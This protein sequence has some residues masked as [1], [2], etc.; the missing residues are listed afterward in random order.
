MKEPVKQSE[1]KPVLA[2]GRFRVL[3][4]LAITT[5]LAVS[6]L[7]LFFFFQTGRELFPNTKDSVGHVIRA[8]G[9]VKKTPI[10]GQSSRESREDAWGRLETGHG[11]LETLH[12]GDQIQT[13]E[14]SAAQVLFFG[15]SRLQIEAASL[16]RFE[17]DADSIAIRMVLG[18][19]YLEISPDKNG[20]QLFAFRKSDGTMSPIPKGKSLALTLSAVERLEDAV[21]VKLVETRYESS[22]TMTDL[23][24]RYLAHGEEV[25]SAYPV[26][27]PPIEHGTDRSPSART[28]RIS[29]PEG[30]RPGQDTFIDINRN[31]RAL[32]KWSA[33]A[34][35]PQD[36]VV[37][38]QVV[39]RPA[40]SY[41]AEDRARK[42]RT[43]TS[44]E[45]QLGMDNV[46]GGGVFLWSVRA[47]TASGAV[48]EGSTPRWIELKFPKELLSPKVLKPIIR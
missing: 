18:R 33:R 19:A 37:G 36:P 28:D 41:P 34:R 7:S 47:V 13:G 39:V 26:L 4:F 35:K 24:M 46:G 21:E 2:L 16:V 31:D 9:T 42:N 8:Y 25:A 27:V 32:F 12:I 29:A 17:E 48:G 44:A 10:A 20:Q 40:F 23:E 30:L 6:C 15:G 43:F 14:E 22:E 5:L 3:P 38:Y 11:I 1:S 45:P